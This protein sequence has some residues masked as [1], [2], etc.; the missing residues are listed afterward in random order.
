[1]ASMY[2]T[3]RISDDRWDAI[4]ERCDWRKTYKHH[5]NAKRYVWL[6]YASEHLY[7]EVSA[8]V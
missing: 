7:G 2:S 3:E 4:C 1:M 5:G 8:H 6:H